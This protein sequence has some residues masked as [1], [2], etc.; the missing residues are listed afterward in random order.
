MKYTLEQLREQNRAYAEQPTETETRKNSTSKAEQKDSAKADKTKQAALIAEYAKI[1]GDGVI[2]SYMSKRNAYIVELSDG[3]LYAI[4]KPNIKTRFC[5]NRDYNG[6]ST[7]ESERQADEMAEHAST[8]TSY[9]L[10]KN[11]EPLENEIAR[12]D[13]EKAEQ[14][15]NYFIQQHA[16]KKPYI[17]GGKYGTGTERLAY[18]Q[19][20]GD[21]DEDRKKAT[22][23]G[24]RL[25][26]AEE[27]NAIINAYKIV[28][29]QFKKRLTVY[30]NRYGLEKLHIWTYYSD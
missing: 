25:A 9:F 14:S 5:F 2:D 17:F 19:F 10:R 8:E 4:E 23:Q 27:I 11:L 6:I 26:T 16:Y 20:F 22:E 7:A 1:Y 13:R 30:L 28:I 15:D 18:I 21:W 12:F 24:G 29:E 3:K